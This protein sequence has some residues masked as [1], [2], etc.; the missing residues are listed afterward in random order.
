MSIAIMVWKTG[1][2]NL[3]LGRGRCSSIDK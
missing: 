3:V 1:N 2:N